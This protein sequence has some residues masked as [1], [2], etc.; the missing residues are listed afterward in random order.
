MPQNKREKN[1]CQQC[2]HE[3]F[4]MHEA[5]IHITSF[6]LKKGHCYQY[7]TCQRCGG[8]KLLKIQ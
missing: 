8:K 6:F 4:T 7:K 5:D 2:K 3:N 1:Q